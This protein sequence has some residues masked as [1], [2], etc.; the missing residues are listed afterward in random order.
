MQRLI[1]LLL[2]WPTLTFAATPVAKI[3]GEKSVTVLKGTTFAI[4]A[5]DSR[6]DEDLQWE[7]SPSIP[8]EV[9]TPVGGLNRS[10][11]IVKGD[12]PAL[13]YKFTV[14]A[15]GKPDNVAPPGTNPPLLR[16]FSALLLGQ[17]PDEGS[18][19]QLKTSKDSIE[20]TIAVNPGA[21]PV[22]E[23][24]SPGANPL[25]MIRGPE[26][27][28]PG[29]D[30]VLD[31]G[32]SRF[33]HEQDLIWVVKPTIK[34]ELMTPGGG[35]KGSMLL[36]RK[37]PAGTY[38]FTLMA[39]GK[40]TNA[41]KLSADAAHHVVSVAT[42]PRLPITITSPREAPDITGRL[43]VSVIVE[44]GRRYLQNKVNLWGN[45]VRRSEELFN[46]TYYT[47]DAMS[48]ELTRLNFRQ[49]IDGNRYA[50]GKWLPKLERAMLIIQ[51]A[52]GKV[53]LTERAP[54]NEAGVIAKIVEIRLR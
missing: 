13:K 45:N 25:A 14:T 42:P 29:S 27:V 40:S 7:V 11:L 2:A 20:V 31:A 6:S 38:E 41:G 10:I 21:T 48:P 3:R 18:L 30:L 37:I 8:M 53:I 50:E 32:E 4:D 33:D 34:F 5:G 17:N 36:V 16:R 9:V 49:Y 39:Q 28:A 23:L 35:P 43:I 47:Y 22:M 19:Y 46:F 54:E 24:A 52:S 51:D 15:K 26:N 1:I 44:P 12:L